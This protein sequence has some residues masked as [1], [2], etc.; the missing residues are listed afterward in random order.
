MNLKY[1]KSGAAFLLAFVS[2]LMLVSC[3]RK[4]K[5]SGPEAPKEAP[6]TP[7]KTITLAKGGVTDYVIVEGE[8]PSPAERT[9]AAD[10]AKFLKKVTGAEFKTVKENPDVPLAKGIYVGWT[11][12]AAR[13]GITASGFAPEE[14]SVTTVDDNLV[15]TGGRPR[16]T[17]NGVYEFLEEAVGVHLLDPR[18]EIIP[19]RND[20]TI[21]APNLSGKPAFL[22]HDIYNPYQHFVPENREFATY[23]NQFNKNE[24]GYRPQ[25]GCTS[26]LG[27]PGG[28]HTFGLYINPKEY[29]ASHPEYFSMNEKGQRLT[30]SK[31][32]PNMWFDLCLSNPEVRKIIIGKLRGYIEADRKTAKSVNLPPPFIY[33]IDQ[34][35]CIEHGCLCPTCKAIIDREGG[36]ESGLTIDFI[37]AIADDIKKDYPDILIQT[38]AYN[39][40]L[41]PPKTIKPRDNVMIRWCDN[42]SRSE[43]FRP[44]TS[45]YNKEMRDLFEPW[46]R[47]SKNMAVWDYWRMFRQHAPGFYAPFVNISCLKPDLEYFQ[48]NG[49]K[50]IFAQSE[51]FLYGLDDYGAD[52]L[53]S[54]NPLRVWLG[55]K[56]MQDP[57]RDEKKL[58][59]TFFNGYYGPAA[60]KM[61]EFL[62]YIEQR[63]NACNQKLIKLD[64]ADY[65][66]AHLDLK[67][68]TTARKM[69][70]E[71]EAACGTNMFYKGRVARERIPVDSALLHLEPSLRKTF[72]ASGEPF[73]FD[74]SQVLAGYASAWDAYLQTFLSEQAREKAKP[75]VEKRLEYLRTMPMISPDSIRHT[76]APVADGGIRID[77]VL[78]EAAWTKAAKLFLTPLAKMQELKVKTVVRTLWSKE[79][80]YLAFECFD[81]KIQDMKFQQ[82]KQDDPD[83]W[84]D[85]SVEI[86]LNPSG[87]HKTYY[88]FVVSPAG[89]LADYAV[90]TIE[91]QKSFDITWSSGAEVAVKINDSSWVVE[92]A[93]P[94]KAMDVEAGEGVSL[95]SNFCR[96]RHQ[97]SDDK[98]DQLMAWS[99][100]LTSGFHDL[101]RFGRVTLG[102]EN[103][104]VLFSSFEGPQDTPSFTPTGGCVT[105]FAKEHA[106]DGA[107]S[108]RLELKRSEDHLGVMFKVGDR[109][110]WADFAALKADVFVEGS[111][112]LPVGF[113]LEADKAFYSALELQPGWNK[114]VALV[115]L[116]KAG[117]KIDLTKVKNFYFYV[118][119]GKATS[120]RVVFLDNLRLI[121]K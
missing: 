62:S 8:N 88:Q 23:F 72:C 111:E 98:A 2:I 120:D 99:P 20:L 61:R 102:G 59:D 34:N 104:D 96:S 78:D 74:R 57:H 40:T 91:G 84:K 110:D 90:K 66:K 67:F 100:L 71:A 6:P 35:D 22:L 44:L 4:G 64:R 118:A 70:E 109:S 7:G 107:T 95:V 45:E 14:W 68:F 46:C 24:V 3:E 112:K 81:D 87:D 39:H 21:N 42:Y 60:G 32:T 36:A 30:D 108:L 114:G 12:F 37:N 18:T 43:F 106:S 16:G 113:R 1:H 27:A 92:M 94:F 31:G 63:Q 121:R 82:R 83:I 86:F 48:K 77:G 51:D 15:M 58:M 26:K 41:N 69:L 50:S 93:I 101:E 105:A 53:Q 13:Q 65:Y 55:L 11:G 103:T 89:I 97:K 49:V 117:E 10:L 115:G 52:D 80:L 5:V 19:S 9:A 79:K 28:C 119:K 85:S 47:I 29:G 25:Y 38:F 56:L 33:C 116:A 73:P 17:L 76:A 54:F 75:F